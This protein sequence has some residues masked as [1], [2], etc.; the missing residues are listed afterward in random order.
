MYSWFYDDLPNQDLSNQLF[1]GNTI[2]QITIC[3]TTNK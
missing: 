3:R 2:R 1:T